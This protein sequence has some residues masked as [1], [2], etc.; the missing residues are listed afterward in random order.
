VREVFAQYPDDPGLQEAVEIGM[1]AF[2]LVPLRK[3]DALLGAITASR[4]EVRSFSDRQ[5]ALL[6][7]FRTPAAV[8]PLAARAWQASENLSRFQAFPALAGTGRLG[9]SGHSLALT[10]LANHQRTSWSPAG[11]SKN[12]CSGDIFNW[13]LSLLPPIIATP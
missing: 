4:T 8:H 6:E 1:R 7:A 11:L 3:D 2:L 9:R 10:T 13:P 12:A 5:I